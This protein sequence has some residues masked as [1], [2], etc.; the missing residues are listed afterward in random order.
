MFIIRGTDDRNTTQQFAASRLVYTMGT[1]L[2]VVY[3]LAWLTGLLI[4]WRRRMPVWLL[5]L[6]IVYVPLTIAPVLTN[7][8]YTLTAQPFVF[9]FVSIAILT[10]LKKLRD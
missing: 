8:R 4:A 1:V 9:V 7:M 5:A 2:S 6:P 10:G 3:L